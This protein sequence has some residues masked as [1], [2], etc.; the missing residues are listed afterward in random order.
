MSQ[1]TLPPVY[2]GAEIDEVRAASLPYHLADQQLPQHW[3]HTGGGEGIVIGI[4]DTGADERHPELERR[5]LD[6]KCFVPRRD[7]SDWQDRNHHGTHV[8]STIAGTSVGVAPNAKLV[9]AKV[10]GDNGSG[11]NRGVAEGIR[12]LVESDVHIINLSLGGAYDDDDT[13]EAVEYAIS[14]G[15]LVVAATGNEQAS[16]VSYP[17]R[18]CIGVGAVD[19]SLKLAYFSNR[20]KHVD[21]VGYGVDIYAAIPRGRYQRMSGT[22]MATPYICGLLANRLSVE[23]RL[24]GSV[25]TNTTEKLLELETLVTDLGPAGR[26]TSYGRGFPDLSRA[27]YEIDAAPEPS[28]S[29]TLTLQVRTALGEYWGSGQINKE[30][31]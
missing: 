28:L 13:R 29:E 8:A 24:L 23:R 30:T 26:D 22:S 9:I 11:S 5:I 25:V 2:R 19:Q 7:S 6:G 15:V 17:A 12:Y 20:G 1:I 3:Q 10:L 16:H 31:E 18:H 4:A 21:L 27:F 14:C